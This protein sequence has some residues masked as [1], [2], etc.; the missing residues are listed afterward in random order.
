MDV[1]VD[2]VADRLGRDIANRREQPSAL[3]QASAGVDDGDRIVSHHESDI[4][5][6]PL[7]FGRHQCVH[8]EVNEDTG[9]DFTHRQR[10]ILRNGIRPRRRACRE[11]QREREKRDSIAR[12]TVGS[13]TNVGTNSECCPS[14]EF[15][16]AATKY[17]RCLHGSKVDCCCARNVARILFLQVSGF[18]GAGG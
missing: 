18:K 14:R 17:A 5:R 12:V 4:R 8:A 1:R 13:P 7:I 2:D 16:D 3:V 6:C 11:P 15:A 10:G 9:R